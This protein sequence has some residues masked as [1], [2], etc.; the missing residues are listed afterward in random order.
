MHMIVY[1]GWEADVGKGADRAPGRAI[2]PSDICHSDYFNAPVQTR[3]I[4]SYFQ[5][6]GL[7]SLLV[8]QCASLRLETAISTSYEIC[9]VALAKKGVTRISPRKTTISAPVQSKSTPWLRMLSLALP[10]KSTKHSHRNTRALH[11]ETNPIQR[12]ITHQTRQRSVF[13]PEGTSS[14]AM[15]GWSQRNRLAR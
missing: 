7:I 4:S 1:N 12:L 2:R 11:R 13:R 9:N 3:L 15:R 10:L 5:W 8:I 6:I 14:S